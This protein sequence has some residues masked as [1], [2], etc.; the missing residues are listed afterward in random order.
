MEKNN[1]N[2]FYVCVLIGSIARKI[3]NYR[4]DV[5]KQLNKDLQ[6]I[7]DYSDVFYC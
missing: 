3:Q 4:Y 7:Y 5:V 1:N 2:L 6:R